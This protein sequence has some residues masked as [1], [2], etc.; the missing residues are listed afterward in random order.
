MRAKKMLQISM[1]VAGMIAPLSTWAGG[2]LPDVPSTQGTDDAP[3][4]SEFVVAPSHHGQGSSDALGSMS[5][6]RSA[7]SGGGEPIDASGSG[8]GSG[9][10]VGGSADVDE[11]AQQ[12]RLQ[13]QQQI[14]TAP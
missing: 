10:E 3:P 7:G 2:D 6:S 8:S 13:E 9:Q 4:G 14:W 1:A 5:A 12:F 11:S